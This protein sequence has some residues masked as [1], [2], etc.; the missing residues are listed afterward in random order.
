M[1]YRLSCIESFLLVVALAAYSV[2][3]LVSSARSVVV[4]TFFSVVVLQHLL[5]ALVDRPLCSLHNL[6][7]VVHI[8]RGEKM[9]CL[10]WSLKVVRAVLE[11]V[12]DSVVSVEDV[13]V[14]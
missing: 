14:G 11:E 8:F 3:L 1:R 2:A 10:D 7:L 6:I 9:R 12:V 4:V 13:L 5:V